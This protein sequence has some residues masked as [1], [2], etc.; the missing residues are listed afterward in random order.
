MQNNLTMFANLRTSENFHIVLWLFKD[1]C[2]VLDFKV[3]GVLMVVPT[4]AMAFYITWQ[5][6][7]DLGE[8]L[9]SLSVVFWIL[10]NSAWMI[11]EFFLAD[12]TR[13]IATVFFAAGILTVSWFYLVLLPQRLRKERMHQRV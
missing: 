10:A 6:R 12:G 2:W 9:H 5:C 11:G 4:V 3:A 1:L 13:P 8:F 7:H